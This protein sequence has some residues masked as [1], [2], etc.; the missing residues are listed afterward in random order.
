M[1]DFGD[2][3][4]LINESIEPLVNILNQK[5]GVFL[6]FFN[7]SHIG[8]SHSNSILRC[9]NFEI[10]IIYFINLRC[11]NNTPPSVT[12]AHA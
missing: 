10:V 3:M 9:G 7:F 11:L 5:N 12:I 8:V 2:K 4:R 1:N 6:T